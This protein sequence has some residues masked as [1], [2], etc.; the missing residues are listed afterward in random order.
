MK[1]ILSITIL[2]V[3]MGSAQS[4]QLVETATAIAASVEAKAMTDA[5]MAI[6]VQ[7]YKKAVSLLKPL[8]KS[9]DEEA[10]YQLATMYRRGQG[11]APDENKAA[12]WMLQSAKQGYMRAQY[13]IGI[14]LEEGIGVKQDRH[15]AVIWYQASAQQGYENAQK[16][17]DRL[18]GAVRN[19]T[20]ED[21][22]VDKASLIQA[23]SAGSIDRAKY[24]LQQGIEVCQSTARQG[25]LLRCDEGICDQ[26]FG[27][28]AS[29]SL[30]NSAAHGAKAHQA[31]GLVP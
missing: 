20:D 4:Y 8:A 6:R 22:T 14:Y 11:I 21:I 7:D 1:K 26:Y 17:L 2:L 9:G 5:K 27:V 18:S 29:H 12:Y 24:L 15:K 13:G 10:Q 19:Q 3:L 31:Y 16:R 30:G 28:E 23:V 25:S